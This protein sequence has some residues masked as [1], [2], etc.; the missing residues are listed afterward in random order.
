[1]KSRER[2]ERGDTR[3]SRSGAEV[4][5]KKLVMFVCSSRTIGYRE[6]N[7]HSTNPEVRARREI[8]NLRRKGKG[9]V[10]GPGPECLGRLLP[11]I[12]RSSAR[13]SPSANTTRRLKLGGTS[14]VDRASALSPR[15]VADPPV[16]PLADA[17][18]GASS[19]SS[20]YLARLYRSPSAIPFSSRTVGS[21]P[22][23][24]SL[25][26][27]L[28]HRV[29]GGSDEINRRRGAKP[30]RVRTEPGP[31]ERKR[32]TTGRGAAMWQPGE[33]RPALTT[34]SDG[35]SEARGSP[36]ARSICSA[37][38]GRQPRMEAAVRTEN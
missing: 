32:C 28:I 24:G 33:A 20:P 17:L 5:F 6:N 12:L 8:R 34:T 25:M 1:M 38:E 10:P 26:R 23:A 15:G 27:Y 11:D 31:G 22:G 7:H 3:G 16:S 30:G 2:G 14:L 29:R 9:R 19:S 37:C 35:P 4:R 13:S 36:R 21:E 18:S